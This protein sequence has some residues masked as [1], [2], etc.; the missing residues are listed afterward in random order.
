MAMDEDQKKC[1][2]ITLV[3]V[4]ALLVSIA[5]IIIGVMNYYPEE[6]TM[7]WAVV[8]LDALYILQRLMYD[9]GYNTFD[10]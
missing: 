6:G 5:M 2:G 8:L 10:N 3:G 4:S 9:C 1:G 7:R